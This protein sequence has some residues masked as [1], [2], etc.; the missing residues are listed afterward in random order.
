MTELAAN[1]LQKWRKLG[2]P[3]AVL[4]KGEQG[5]QASGKVFLK[6]WSARERKI[7]AFKNLFG[8]WGLCLIALFIPVAHFILV[9]ALFLAAPLAAIIALRQRSRLLGGYTACPACGE[10]FE[11]I[12]VSNSFP[13]HDTC[14]ACSSAVRIESTQANSKLPDNA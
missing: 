8:L 6:T 13:F 2:E 7:R 9:P 11:I 10:E 12:C 5:K 14:K 3:L 4:V 1:K